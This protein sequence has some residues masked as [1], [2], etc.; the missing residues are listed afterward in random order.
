MFYRKLSFL[1]L[2]ALL[3]FAAACKTQRSEPRE[4][5]PLALKNVPAQRLNYK[6]ETDVPPPELKED[7]ETGDDR[8]EA[9][10]LDFDENRAQEVLDRTITSPDQQRVVAVYRKINDLITEFRLDM[11]SVDGKLIKKITHDEMAV[12]FPGTI[13]W[14]PNS[15]TVAFIAMVRGGRQANPGTDEE[16]KAALQTTSPTVEEKKEEPKPED[17]EAEGDEANSTS[18]SETDPELLEPPK[19]VLTFRTEQIYTCDSEGASVKPLTQSEGLMYFY[20]VW[21][22]DSSALVALASPYTEWRMREFQMTEAGERFAPSGR[23]RLIE[24]NGRE[25]LLDDYPTS[26]QPV[27]SP[28]SA[29]VAVAYDKQVRIYDVIG[30]RPTQAAIPLRNRLLL[31]SKVFEDTKKKEEAE[32]ANSEGGENNNSPGEDGQANV[33]SNTTEDNKNTNANSNVE[34]NTKAPTSTLPDEKSLASFNPIITLRW[35][36]EPMLYLETG[37]VREYIE[38]TEENRRSFLRWH[39]LIFSPQAVVLPGGTPQ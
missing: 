38:N 25:R 35:E 17:S 22:P 28:D 33:E 16:K 19:D 23:P 1:T 9:V 26:V 37:Y 11:Y 7:G 8:N 36:Q 21:A 5:V 34:E 32:N 10:Q 20:A 18:E 31:A 2:L 4:V 6:F 24:R 13:V 14:S 30:E 15:T 27:F 3:V 29:K 39:R 12:H